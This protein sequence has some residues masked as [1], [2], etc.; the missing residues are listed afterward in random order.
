MLGTIATTIMLAEQH[1]GGDMNA[2]RAFRKGVEAH[3]A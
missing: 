2:L 3:I 1:K